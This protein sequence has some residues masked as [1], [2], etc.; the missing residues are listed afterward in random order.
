LL[1]MPP[2]SVGVEVGWIWG[3][4]WVGVGL[5]LELGWVDL[6]MGG[7][8]CF[9]GWGGLAWVKGWSEYRVRLDQGYGWSWV[10]YRLKMGW[11]V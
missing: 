1:G 4:N 9:Y 7:L 2:S 8:R 6:G 3:R 11:L 5:G 10:G